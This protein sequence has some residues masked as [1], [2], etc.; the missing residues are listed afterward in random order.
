MKPHSF[1]NILFAL[2]VGIGLAGLGCGKSAPATGTTAT[3]GTTPGATGSTPSTP[4]TPETPGTPANPAGTPAAP[5]TAQASAPAVQYNFYAPVSEDGLKADTNYGYLIA[6]TPEGFKEG[7]FTTQGLSIEGKFN[8]NGYTYY[9]LHK[10]SG[11]ME[12]LDGLKTTTGVIFAEPE[13]L[14]N[15]HAGITYSNPDPRALSEEYSIYL[16]K[17]KEAWTTYGFGT[18]RPT[19]VDVDTGIN[20]AHED[21]KDVVTHAYSWYSPTTSTTSLPSFSNPIDLVGTAQTSTDGNGHGTHTAGTIAA[22][23]NNGKGVAGVCWNVDL[24]S[25]KGLSDAGSGG[26]WAIYGSIYHLIQWKKANYNHTI[27]VN[28]SLGGTGASQFAIDMIEAGL[29]NN[30]V[31]IAS[32]GNAGTNLVQF[33]S[34]YSGVIGVGATNGQDKKVHFS[35]SSRTISV[36]APG[37]DIISCDAF[38]STGYASESGTSMSAPF[39]TGLVA[40][41]LTF[42]PDLTP[43]Q[44]KTYLEANADLIEGATGYTETTGWGRVNV[45]KTIAAVVAD[46]TAGRTPASSYVN[47]VQRIQV[48][49]VFN[50]KTTPLNGYPVYLYRCDATGAL[51]NYVASSITVAGSIAASA[52]TG[53]PVP[54][55]GVS[56]FNLLKPGTYVAK[57]VVSGNL[58]TTPVF[59]VAAGATSLPMQVIPLSLP[60]YNVQTLADAGSG[61]LTDTV[62]AVYNP[63]GTR[64]ALVDSVTLDTTSLILT[65]PGTYAFRIYPYSSMTYGGEYALWVGNGFYGP[66]ASTVAPGTFASPAAGALLGSQKTL[67]TDPQPVAFDQLYNCIMD[68]TAGNWY[69]FIVP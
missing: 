37:Y 36:S 39:V 33:P 19:V 68:T 63:A 10:D 47:A 20:F 17:A 35:N 25:Y 24:I 21:L 64:I 32:M 56:F 14:L 38:D 59:T 44:I 5:G 12:A 22:M 16:T 8:L 7:L 69:S 55:D 65:T 30:I 3:Q 46:K 53:T 6:K 4:A 52:G 62:I 2:V 58:L 60:I 11:V 23:G 41:M 26:A 57:A 1:G 42:D 31:V 40:Y 48:A 45:L 50:G 61:P 34:G 13:L 67:Q 29:E 66:S 15:S 27:P 43:A 49:N 54:E 28:M 18:N 51:T 9:R